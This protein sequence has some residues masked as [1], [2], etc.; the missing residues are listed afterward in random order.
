[1]R[2][3]VSCS[4]GLI[5]APHLFKAHSI[6]CFVDLKKARQVYHGKM[7]SESYDSYMT[8]AIC[9]M[10]FAVRTAHPGLSLPC[11]VVSFHPQSLCLQRLRYTHIWLAQWKTSRTQAAKD[12]LVK[13]TLLVPLNSHFHPTWLSCVPPTTQVTPPRQA[14][15]QM[16]MQLRRGNTLSTCHFPGPTPGSGRVF[17]FGV[18][19]VLRHCSLGSPW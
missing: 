14:I 9:S 19:R 11:A 5:Q 13:H 7:Y 16:R 17:V 15:L 1:M 8:R 2:R 6:S 10:S 3:L 4:S 18:V 12:T